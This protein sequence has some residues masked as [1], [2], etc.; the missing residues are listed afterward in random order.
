MKVLERSQPLK[1]K[2]LEVWCTGLR[3]LTTQNWKRKGCTAG[4]DVLY[5]P[6]KKRKKQAPLKESTISY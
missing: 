6:K 5:N 4:K 1:S 2:T 3:K